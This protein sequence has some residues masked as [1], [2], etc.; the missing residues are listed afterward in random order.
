MTKKLK[1]TELSLSKETLRAIEDLGFEEAT[2]IQSQAIPIVMQGSDVIGQAITGSG[3][4]IAFGIPVVEKIDPKIHAPQALIMCPTRE[5]AIQ[6]AV[7]LNKILK[8]KKHII[9]LPV[10]GGQPIERQIHALGRGAHIIIGTPGRLLDH[11]MRKTMSFKA[12]KIVVLDEADEMLDMGFLED[13]QA[14]LDQTP[15]TRQTITF[16]ATM[17]HKVLGLVRRYQK[18]PVVIRIEN[19]RITAPDIEQH[20]FEVESRYKQDLLART[21]DLYNPKLSIVF[22]N[23]KRRVDDV[24][25]S[26]RSQGYSAEGI[27][28]DITQPKRNRVMDRFRKGDIDILV[29][30]DVAA[31]GIDVPNIDIVFNFE[32]PQDAESYVH[33]VGRTG[34]AGKKG[35]AYSFVSGREAYEFRNIKR[36]T[37]ANITCEQIPSSEQVEENKLV[38]ILDEIRLVISK[39]KLEKYEHILESLLKE[40]FTSLQIA[41]ALFKMVRSQ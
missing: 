38:K 29:A 28:G 3:K 7:E 36:F 22:C 12:L 34:R 6:T 13:I 31:R 15:K 32:V 16:S 26:L 8:Y 18:D 23:T 1:F 41:A 40:D 35:K 19:E 11:L 20:Y 33:R 17:P 27:H 2:P 24:V 25:S 9:A 10:Y 37:K 30:T 5:L 14:I 39:S 4:T 21:I